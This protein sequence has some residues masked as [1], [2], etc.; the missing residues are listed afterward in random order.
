LSLAFASSAASSALR[1]SVVSRTFSSSSAVTEIK[2][3]WDTPDTLYDE[4]RLKAG[5]GAEKVRL[6]LLLTLL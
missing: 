4:A 5:S 6:F 2:N 1:R 3:K